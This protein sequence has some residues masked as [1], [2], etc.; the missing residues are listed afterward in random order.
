VLSSLNGHRPEE[1]VIQGFGQA[2]GDPLRGM[3]SADVELL[4]PDD[5]LT[6]VDR[7]SMAVGLEVRPPLVDHELLELT[8][9]MP[10]HLKVHRGETKRLFKRVCRRF[11]PPEIIDRP[12]QGFDVPIDD[13]LRGPLRDQFHAYVLAPQAAAAGHI[14]QTTAAKLYDAHR[15]RVGRHGNLLWALLVL[16]RWCEEYL[17]S[18]LPVSAA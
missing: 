16:G 2:T 17:P 18:G 4:L 8:A 14:N 9:R 6:K 5:F 7:A 1:R 12:K 10:S 15:R 11:L 3:I 13:W